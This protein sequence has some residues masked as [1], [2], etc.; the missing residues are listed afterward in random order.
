MPCNRI[1]LI[2]CYRKKMFIKNYKNSV[3]IEFVV[4]FILNKP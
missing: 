3:Y 4:R 1:I 2:N